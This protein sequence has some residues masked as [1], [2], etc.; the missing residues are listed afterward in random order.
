MV[1]LLNC[2]SKLEYG[3]GTLGLTIAE[4]IRTENSPL[5]LGKL[6]LGVANVGFTRANIPVAR[7]TRASR[8]VVPVNA[9]WW[10]WNDAV[11]SARPG[12]VPAVTVTGAEG[13]CVGT[14]TVVWAGFAMCV[15][16][17]A[18]LT[19]SGLAGLMQARDIVACCVPGW[20]TVTEVGA[21]VRS[22]R[23]T[24]KVRV[25]VIVWT[26]EKRPEGKGAQTLQPRS[27]CEFPRRPRLSR[28][29]PSHR[30]RA[31]AERS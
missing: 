3:G 6:S 29:L 23:F 21:N 16:F 9:A 27:G 1:P 26:D 14:V 4:P 30:C 2:A 15:R 17:V 28:W 19:T 5:G 22:G 11:I 7:F 10:C 18:R 31:S 8:R 13:C 24:V 20:E 25:A 12:L